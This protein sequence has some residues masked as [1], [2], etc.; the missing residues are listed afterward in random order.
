M[1]Q[2]TVLVTIPPSLY[3]QLFSPAAQARLQEVARVS[4]NQG[5]RNWTSEELA[6]RIG[7]FDAVITGWGTPTFTAQV[8]AA[9]QELRLIAHSAGSIKKMLPPAVFDSELHVTH[10]AAAIAPA[11]AEMTVLLILLSLRQVHQLDRRLKAGVPWNETRF[12]GQELAGQ[13]VGVVGAGH[14]GR[15]VIRLLRAWDAEVWVADP[16]LDAERATQL[17]VTRVSL[18]E[19]FANCAIVTMQAPPTDETYRMVKARHL[20][21]LPD[22]AIFVNTARSHAVDND[23]LLAELQSGR[24]Q[25]ALDVFDQE[26]LPAD[27]PFLQLENVIVTPHVAGASRQARLRQGSVIVEEVIRFFS[28]E[29]LRYAV[30]GEMLATMA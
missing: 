21:S 17:G 8:L 29:P 16:Y 23:A 9:A 20:A 14:T 1:S 27:S 5:E 28:G 3:Q 2:P 26:P 12:M 10:A 22:G 24:I 19:L 7:G 11:V 6:Q 13:R 25:A 30:T 15:C 18:D 4:F